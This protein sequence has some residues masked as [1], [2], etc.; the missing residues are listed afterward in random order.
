MPIKAKYV[1]AVDLGGTKV[2]A[3]FVT[4]AGKIV[5]RSTEPVDTSSA[6]APVRQ[7]ARLAADLAEDDGL[8]KTV[9]SAAVAVPGLVRRNGTVW[10]PNL[11]GWERMP[12]RARLEKVVEVPV[13]VESD[14]NAAVLGETWMGAARGKSDAVVLII[15]TGIGAGI[16]AGGT[17]VRGAHELSG[18]AGWLVVSDKCNEQAGNV[19][20]LESFT[21][22]PGIARMAAKLVAS[23]V[24]RPEITT[25]DVAEAARQG[26]T[27]AI[28]MF[29]DAG[30]MLGRGVANIVSMFDPEVIVIGGGMAATADLFM[31]SLR[32]SMLQWAQPLAARQIKL[33][34]SKLG[35]DANLLG[36]AHLAWN[37][38]EQKS[39]RT[40]NKSQK[41]H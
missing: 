39:N 6:A 17:I 29:E 37:I 10:A 33:A 30:D 26:D 21:A 4:R 19:G 38:A 14:R 25:R 15:G 28:R 20:Y 1:L 36:A 35:G 34:V 16:L 12:L 18:C 23:G 22:G 11:P 32:A 9:A 13:A 40:A 31:P 3:A 41:R 27:A 5:A 8:H 24:N 2:A 7:I